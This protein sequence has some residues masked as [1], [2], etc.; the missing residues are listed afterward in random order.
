MHL[1]QCFVTAVVSSGSLGEARVYKSPGCV[2][3]P[4]TSIGDGRVVVRA[5]D[6]V[7]GDV[8]GFVLVAG[9]I[10]TAEPEKRVVV[11]AVVVGLIVR[12]VGWLVVF[13]VIV[14]GGS[15]RGC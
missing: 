14:P 3:E 2:S 4:P 7:G 13:A 5:G 9:V 15:T 12:D 10:G 11:M 6:D 8:D 1:E